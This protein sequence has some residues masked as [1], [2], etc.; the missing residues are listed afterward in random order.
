V[1]GWGPVGGLLAPIHDRHGATLILV[2][3]GRGIAS[4]PEPANG[5]GPAS[6]PVGPTGNRSADR[7]SRERSGSPAPADRPAPAAPLSRPWAVKASTR[8]EREPVASPSC[9]QT[10]RGTVAQPSLEKRSQ[11]GRLPRAERLRRGPWRRVRLRP[12]PGC[13][14][15]GS[16]PTTA[17]GRHTPAGPAL[18]R[19]RITAPNP[20]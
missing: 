8:R 11:G 6:R 18:Q 20:L 16:R 15:I 19:G 14:M 3:V 7:R 17:G 12:S 13:P 1:G 5:S 4:L 9:G 10:R 2:I